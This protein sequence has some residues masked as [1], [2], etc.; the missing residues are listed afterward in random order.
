MS[1]YYVANKGARGEAAR[2][3]AAVALRR[4]TQRRRRELR[5]SQKP[6]RI[7]RETTHKGHTTLLEGDFG[8][9]LCESYL[10]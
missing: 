5:A 6:R 10:K 2:G 4:P 7:T 3:G 1:E 9:T 8:F